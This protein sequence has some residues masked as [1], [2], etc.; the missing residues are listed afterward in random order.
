MGSFYGEAFNV[1]FG[2]LVSRPICLRGGGRDLVLRGATAMES[3]RP[4]G[5]SCSVFCLCD[6][7][8]GEVEWDTSTSRLGT[9]NLEGVLH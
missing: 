7:S 8:A 4:E 3:R 2:N 1:S 5:G 6:A 9:G